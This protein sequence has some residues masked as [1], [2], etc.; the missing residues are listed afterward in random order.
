MKK[1]KKIP[2]I[3]QVFFAI[4]FI[5]ITIFMGMSVYAAPVNPL[6]KEVHQAD[7]TIINAHF[8]GDEFFNWVEDENG[9]VIAYNQQNKNWYYAEIENDCIVPSEEIVIENNE[10]IPSVN[11]RI[12]RNNIQYLIQNSA[13]NIDNTST[14]ETGMNE[15][16]QDIL[17]LPKTNQELLLLLIEF[18]DVSIQ[19]NSQYWS[20]KYF[21]GDK[22]VAGYYRDMSNGLDIITPAITQNIGLSSEITANV[23][24]DGADENINVFPWANTGVNVTISSTYDG[25]IKVKF[26]MDHPMPEYL[27]GKN[28]KLQTAIVTMAL[29]A[30]KENTTYDFDGYGIN[31][32]VSAIVAGVE[33]SAQGV[34]NTKGEMWAHSSYFDSN[35]IGIE[36]DMQQYM[37]HGEM[38]NNTEA[39]GIG[40]AC[41]E[42]GHILG[43]PDLYNFNSKSG[44]IGF[45]SSMAEGLWGASQEGEVPGTTPVSLDAWSKIILGYII[46]EEYEEW[47]FDAIEVKNAG[48]IGNGTN[49]EYNVLRLNNSTI[50]SNQYFLIENRQNNGWDQGMQTKLGDTF[51]GGILILQIDSNIL[52]NNEIN[53]DDNHRGVD[54]VGSSGATANNNYFYAIGNGKTK[55]DSRTNPSSA[56]YSAIGAD[57][58]NRDENSDITVKIKSRSLNNMTVEVG[59]DGD[60]TD[61]FVDDN[62]LAEIRSITGK[63][64]D[65]LIYKSDVINIT[66]FDVS[67]K[68]IYSCEGIK[69]F[70]RLKKFQCYFNDFQTLDVSN[71]KELEI[72]DCSYNV[73]I[74][75]LNISKNTKLKELYCNY[76]TLPSIDVSNNRDLIKLICYD[77]YFEQLNVSNNKDLEK[78]DCW[79][80][81]LTGL[82]IST[83]KKIKYLD[84]SFNKMESYDD[85][86]GWKENGLVLGKTFL[87]DPQGNVKT[88]HLAAEPRQ[89]SAGA[90]HSVVINNFGLVQTYGD[91]TYKQ[92]GETYADS[93]NPDTYYVK[94]INN[95]QKVST[96][97]NHNLALTEGKVFAWGDNSHYQLGRYGSNSGEVKQVKF[98]ANESYDNQPYIT[99][100]EAGGWFS[101]ALDING[102]IWAW[103]DNTYGQFSQG[104]TNG[105]SPQPHIVYDNGQWGLSSSNTKKI[106]A[107]KYH[108]LALK[109]NGDVYGWGRNSDDHC[110]SSSDTFSYSLVTQI[111]GLPK[112]IVGIEAGDRCS[113]FLTSDGHVYAMG[114]NS[115]GQLGD[116]TNITRSTPVLLDVENVVDI[117]SN[118]GTTLFLTSNGNVFACGLN[119][120]GQLGQG[121]VNTRKE[122]PVKVPDGNYKKIAVG[123]YHN[124]LYKCNEEYPE[125]QLSYRNATI[126]GM[127]CNDSGQCI[128]LKKENITYPTIVAQIENTEDVGSF[129]W[130][131]YNLRPI[132][133]TYVAQHDIEQS[134][135][136]YGDSVLKVNYTERENN[137][138]Y[139][140]EYSY[141]K[142]NLKDIDRERVKSA[143]LHLYVENGED[144]RKSIRE[145]GVYDTYLNNWDGSTMTWASGRKDARSLLGSFTV[146]ATGHMIEDVGWHEV[147]IT[148]YLRN[149]C[150]DNELSL[151]L[152]SIST[153]AYET[154][155]TGGVYN[156]SFTLS[157]KNKN[158]NMPVLEVELY[159][160]EDIETIHSSCPLLADTYTYQQSYSD[161]FSSDK[162][163]SVN[164]TYNENQAGYWGQDAYLSFNTGDMSLIEKNSIENAV[165]W[166]YVD[167]TS[168]IRASTRTINVSANDGIKYNADT[169][170]WSS[171]RMAGENN[172]GDFEVNGNGYNI[173]NPGWRQINV[174]DFIKTSQNTNVEFILKMTSIQAHPVKIRSNENPDI[175]TRPKLVIQKSYIK[176]ISDSHV[177]EICMDKQKIYQYIPS[178]DDEY[179]FSSVDG[180]LSEAILIDADM[181]ELVKS[182]NAEC[183]FNIKYPLKK[184]KKYYIKLLSDD[185][186]YNE[187]RLYVET[188]LNI[189]IN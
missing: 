12:K 57:E 86:V 136:F 43:L 130:S 111:K 112:N 179:I 180:R 110:I 21:S 4:S 3:W 27:M 66:K 131:K 159:E 151:M 182:D 113:F 98:Y 75:S 109:N 175:N 72:L 186:T 60:I 36:G 163:L 107:G 119:T 127:G 122:T 93:S 81:Y 150:I 40:V 144:N 125:E 82:D 126:Y 68:K 172:I 145:I 10:Q 1:G 160:D 168:D 54:I 132:D 77:C 70:R 105:Y 171:G 183:D 108:A 76:S 153:Q 88:Y 147:D 35:V 170:T 49:S 58:T 154:I 59:T 50:D 101:L 100:V 2:L 33:K 67:D 13:L 55:M 61:E 34:H 181:N 129:A 19:K 169:L 140:G 95:I 11:D 87:F 16:N 90:N 189:T 102:D 99:D 162:F 41:H 115:N 118:E 56:F 17:K 51:K 161:N 97:Q 174:T 37:L 30:I 14:Y 45:Y 23:Q 31:K 184:D 177:T 83:N 85:V 134:K 133:A 117:E 173:V 38:Y 135:N 22:S 166:V 187:C 29:K 128:S 92:L 24:Y 185:G 47:E 123:G 124:L 74:V 158:K 149:N 148:E 176:D 53:A 64:S 65:E 73:D 142:F 39:V 116:G 96:F 9:N 62:F 52:L 25:I 69:Y 141:L 18:N 42:L 8:Y 188:P 48:D 167:E 139:W 79:G 63:N 5:F 156:D 78:L 157:D 6:A 46:P 114:N 103:G 143:K 44:G 26:N 15:F 178:K 164:Y 94:G 152:K 7:G 84:C 137:S 20:E 28:N 104:T 91:N 146:T 138:N 155:I 165:L 80:N 121:Y 106:S 89:I 32:Y 120:H 71:N